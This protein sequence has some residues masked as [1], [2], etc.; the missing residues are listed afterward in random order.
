MKRYLLILA[1]STLA[2]GQ[3]VYDFSAPTGATVCTNSNTGTTLTTPAF[4]AS[5]AYTSVRM[6]VQP[7]TPNGHYYKVTV[8]GTSG[9]EP[10]PWNTSGGTSTSGGVTFQD[11]GTNN[12]GQCQ[13]DFFLY[14]LPAIDGTVVAFN[15]NTIDPSNGGCTAQAAGGYSYTAMDSTITGF[16]G[17]AEWTGSDKVVL[18]L[19]VISNGSTNSITPCYWLSPTYAATLSAPTNNVCF[20]SAGQG[21]TYPGDKP[22]NT[23]AC[24][25]TGTDTTG[26]PVP[27]DVPFNTGYANLLSSY[28]PH[29]NAAAYKTSVAYSRNSGGGPGGEAF[30][31]CAV[32]IK[33]TYSYT[34]S[35]FQTAWKNNVA[36]IATTL[37]GASPTFPVMG[38]MDGTCPDLQSGCIVSYGMADAEATTY[39]GHSFGIGSQ[40]L[41]ESD[42]TAFAAHGYTSGST[43]SS[44]TYCSGDFC[45]NFNTY[46]AATPLELQTI[47]ASNPT[48]AG[49]GSLVDLL[50]LATQVHATSAELYNQDLLI[51]YDPN[52]PQ[53]STYHTA[54]AAAIA[55]YR[56]GSPAPTPQPTGLFGPFKIVGPFKVQ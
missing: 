51:A 56:A 16:T 44:G 39:T 15:G 36:S 21:A 50:N 29:I 11:R 18:L 41:S 49:T 9:T 28:L 40:G 26:V 47:A 2:W 46:P 17:A 34:T 24:F 22:A 14:I 30:P 52:Y 27:F 19:R 37:A 31:H 38:S 55:S 25:T 20:C 1:L 7:T 12:N 6:W 4:Q 35:Q 54:Y 8:T 13:D 45:Y 33:T 32:T 23:N 5:F 43:A 53:Y 42:V 48:G 3:K 10:S